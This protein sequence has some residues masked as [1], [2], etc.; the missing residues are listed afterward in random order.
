MALN[1]IMTDHKGVTTTYHKIDNV[2]VEKNDTGYQL[3]LHL[4]SYVSEA[5]RFASKNNYAAQSSYLVSASLE[6]VENMPIMTVAYHALKQ[7]DAFIDA[8]DC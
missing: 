6:E 2:E 5:W 7:L 4:M 8:E 1:K 3:Y